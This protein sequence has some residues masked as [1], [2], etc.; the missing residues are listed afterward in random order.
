[1]N[2]IALIIVYLLVIAVPVLIVW[3][4][5]RKAQQKKL[6]A[7]TAAASE[8]HR[9]ELNDAR[10][11]RP[12]PYSAPVSRRTPY[13]NTSNLRTPLP[14]ANARP[15]SPDFLTPALVG[16]MLGSASQHEAR[17]E[18]PAFE[19]GGGSFG[20]GGASGGWNDDRS[21]SCDSGSSSSS[22]SGSSSSCDSGGS[23]GSSE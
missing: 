16:Y 6:T 1:M 22:D 7:R 4:F 9:L 17:Q 21:S 19:G 11:S 20:G 23:S 18:S 10:R 2:L 14:V 8:R 12:I 13:H 3:H 5:V 15:D